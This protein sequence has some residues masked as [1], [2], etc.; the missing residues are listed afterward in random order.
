MQQFKQARFILYIT[1]FVVGVLL[2][3]ISTEVIGILK[4]Q[5]DADVSVKEKVTILTADHLNDQ[6]WGSLAYKGMLK[7]EERF[8]VDVFLFSEVKTDEAIKETVETAIESESKLIIGHGREFSEMFSTLA[9]QYKDVRFITVHGHSTQSNQTVYTFDQGVIE[10][11]AGLTAALKTTSKQVAVIDSKPQEEDLIEFSSALMYYLPEATFHYRA[12]GTRDDGEKATQLMKELLTLG[13]DV[14]YSRGNAYNQNVIDL[15]KEK[16]VYVIGYLDDQSYM[17]HDVVLTSVLNDVP[18]VYVSI[19]ED[20][21]SEEGI[22]SGKVLLT[23]E[24]GVYKLA[25]FGP[26][27]SKKEIAYIESEIQKFEKG[28]LQFGK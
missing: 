12:V 22:P 7:I 17:G 18:Q 10:H 4:G 5:K 11:F 14:I 19:M 21:F 27:F 23:K 28:E 1:I 2:F 15:A 13:V 25:P 24:D 16:G 9:S 26:M 8:P 6:S 20:Y 3:A